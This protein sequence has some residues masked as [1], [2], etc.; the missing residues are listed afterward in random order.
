[1]NAACRADM[2]SIFT[3]S[4]AVPRSSGASRSTFLRL[5]Q[6]F[7]T[8]GTGRTFETSELNRAQVGH[9]QECTDGQSET[10]SQNAKAGHERTVHCQLQ[11]QKKQRRGDLEPMATRSP[12]TLH[13]TCHVH[14]IITVRPKNNSDLIPWA[15]KIE[16]ESCK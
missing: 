8:Q 3:L 11:P 12:H 1:M 16:F 15:Q 5:H 13:P 10:S 2:A 4:E 7:P 9:F 6:P 14:Q